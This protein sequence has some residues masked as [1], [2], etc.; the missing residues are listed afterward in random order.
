MA[1]FRL[2]FG[3]QSLLIKN[4]VILLFSPTELCYGF[5]N[6]Y[7]K[8]ENQEF[9]T[10]KKRSIFSY[11]HCYNVLNSTLELD[12]LLSLR[13]STSDCGYEY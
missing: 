4:F 9:E 7:A 11:S 5:K 10:F 3:T 13:I 8:F 1:K 6:I 2:F 12:G